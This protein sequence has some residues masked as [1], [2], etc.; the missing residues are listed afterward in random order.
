MNAQTA[1]RRIL[2]EAAPPASCAAHAAALA[3]AL[4][5]AL[6]RAL[7]C[8]LCCVL[9]GTACDTPPCIT[10]EDCPPSAPICTLSECGATEP[11]FFGELNQPCTASGICDEGLRCIEDDGDPDTKPSCRSACTVAVA[12]GSCPSGFECLEVPSTPGEGACVPAG[13]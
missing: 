8:V 5:R 6:C 2:E 11:A 13:G 10:D 4:C 1:I 3:G 12:M 7:C 9:W